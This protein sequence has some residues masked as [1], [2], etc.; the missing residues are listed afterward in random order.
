MT[1]HHT[2]ATH[3]ARLST[4]EHHSIPPCPRVTATGCSSVPTCFRQVRDS[5]TMLRGEA[6]AAEAHSSARFVSSVSQGHG[7]LHGLRLEACSSGVGLTCKCPGVSRHPGCDSS[8]PLGD[9]SYPERMVAPQGCAS[10]SCQPV[11]PRSH[12]LHGRYAILCHYHRAM[13]VMQCCH[14]G[15]SLLPGWL[16]SAYSV[17]L[18]H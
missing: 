18:L 6:C 3:T 13:V 1:A 7:W 5:P 10:I 12:S 17:A 16:A 15:C 11:C 14:D 4:P 9:S 8:T 2:S